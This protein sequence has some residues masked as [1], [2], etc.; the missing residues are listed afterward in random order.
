M[1]CLSSLPTNWDSAQTVATD[2]RMPTIQYSSTS[3]NL[4]SRSRWLASDCWLHPISLPESVDLAQAKVG[5]PNST[6]PYHSRS[7][8]A[9]NLRVHTKDCEYPSRRLRR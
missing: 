6:Y 1:V 5:A 3:N 4:A 7:V 9:D 8:L 2:K